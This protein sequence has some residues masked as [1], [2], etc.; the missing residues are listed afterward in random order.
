MVDNLWRVTDRRP[1]WLYGVGAEPDPRFTLAN[2]RTLLAWIRTA[3]AFAAAGGGILL[4]RE[5]IGTWAPMASAATFAVALI[6]ALGAVVRWARMERALRLGEPLPGPGLAML[7]S[8]VI[9]TGA[10]V[11][12]VTLLR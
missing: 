2:E 9:V 11:G 10:L 5:A 12:I 3:I 8:A 6:V 1:R 7:I 4:A